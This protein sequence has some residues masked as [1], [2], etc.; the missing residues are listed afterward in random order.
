M[1]EA[2]MIKDKKEPYLTIDISPQI[3]EKLGITKQSDILMFLMGDGLFVRAKKR[4]KD[5]SG[6]KENKKEI[7]HTG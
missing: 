4:N 1:K 7:N 3:A 2:R 6:E 5:G